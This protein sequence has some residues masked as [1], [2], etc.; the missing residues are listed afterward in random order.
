[1]PNSLKFLTAVA[2]LFALSGLAVSCKTGKSKP[3]G[4]PETSSPGETGKSVKAEPETAKP[5]TAKPETAKP[6]NGKP[7]EKASQPAETPPGGKSETEAKATAGEVA[8]APGAKSVTPKTTSTV[9]QPEPVNPFPTNPAEKK[10]S[11]KAE[12]A[13]ITSPVVPLMA[14]GLED[15]VL[16]T[17]LGPIGIQLY[18]DECPAHCENFKNLVKSGFYNHIGFHVVCPG[19]V[20]TGDPS[21][22]GEEGTKE[23]I[24][25]E[26]KMP[27]IKGAVAA[28]RKM[29]D[30]PKRESHG[31]QFFIMKWDYPEFNNQ[32]TVFGRV[33]RGWDVLEKG[34]NSPGGKGQGVPDS[35]R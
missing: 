4:E 11:T 23:T 22:R 21:G 28:A 24:P 26:I 6:E 31:S 25:A 17:D 3:S 13:P 1:M 34:K 7:G 8:S 2:V 15:V 5:E 35:A 18:E 16:N 32:Y 19:F 27:F 20:Q 9:P 33:T 14:N 29:N 10:D 12:K 30:N